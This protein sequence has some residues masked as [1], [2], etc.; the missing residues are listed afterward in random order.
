MLVLNNYNIHTIVSPTNVFIP[1]NFEN[2]WIFCAIY[3]V[4]CNFSLKIVEN[5]CTDN[6]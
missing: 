5:I 2:A 3:Y 6:V 4:H 1:S